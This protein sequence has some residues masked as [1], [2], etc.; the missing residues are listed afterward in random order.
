MNINQIFN[1]AKN[2][3]SQLKPTKYNANYDDVQFEKEQ[4]LQYDT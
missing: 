2:I 1:S 3:A 4:F